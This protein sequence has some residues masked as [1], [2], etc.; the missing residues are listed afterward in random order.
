MAE[1]KQLLEKLA[2]ALACYCNRCGHNWSRKSLVTLPKQCPSCRS[3]YWAKDRVRDTPVRT[4]ADLERAREQAQQKL[5]AA[6]LRWAARTA[7]ANSLKTKE[8]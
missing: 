8:S 7:R 5:A 2:A 3:P 4:A 6:R 1:N